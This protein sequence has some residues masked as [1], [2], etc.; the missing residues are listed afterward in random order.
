MGEAGADR[1]ARRPAVEAVERT[2]LDVAADEGDRLDVFL[3]NAPHQHAVIAGLRG[4]E[5][6]PFDQRNGVADAGD[7]GEPRRDAVVIV[8]RTVDRRR[9]DMAVHA[10]D[11]AEQLD[12][13]AVHH[14]HHDDQR[15]D[16]EHDA[17]EGEAG[18][19]RDEPLAAARAKIAPGELP[20][21]TGEGL[22]SGRNLAGRDLGAVGDGAHAAAPIRCDFMTVPAV[23]PP[24][25]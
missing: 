23:T 5:R 24:C 6:L 18:D 14:R 9:E 10:D 15:G 13:E 22:G 25:P 12:A 20:F 17:E 2:G 8:E 7:L 21:E 16:A 11:L 1:D 4:G 3:A 19:D